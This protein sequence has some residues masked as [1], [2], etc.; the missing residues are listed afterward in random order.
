MTKDRFA[1][2]PFPDVRVSA[3][4]RL[5]LISL[6]DEYVEDYMKRYEEFVE[7]K[8][9]VDKRRWEHVKSKDNLRVYAE[10]TPKELKRRG[11]EPEN[12]LSATQRLKA[13]STAKDL[14]VMFSV[15]TFVGEL[16]DLMYGVL[17]PT[18]D[19][20]RIKAS[21]V[22]DLDS[23]AVLCSV[24]GPSKD[25]PFRSLVIKWMEID[26]PLQSTHLVKSRDFVYI[27]ATGTMYLSNGDRVGYHLLHSI[28]FPQTKPLPGKIRANMSLFGC[29]RQ[30]DRT[31]VD[32]FACATIDPGGDMLRSLLL[33]VA[34]G[35]MLSA[36][37]FVYCGQMKKLAWLL[38]RHHSAYD[39]DR[40]ARQRKGCVVC[41]KKTTSVLGSIGKSTCKIC[42]GCVCYSCKIRQC[43]S[44][45]VVGGRLIQRKVVVCAKCMGEST[46]W[47][48]QEAVRDQITEYEACKSDDVCTS[49]EACTVSCEL[50]FLESS[51]SILGH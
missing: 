36:T 38:Q 50:S 26:V 33:S 17:N 3:L 39:A 27:E 40:T 13:D 42:Y 51:A 44:F 37:N 43:I 46:Q 12:S 14:P 10:R 6:V 20:M 18:L 47:N 23:A 5:E 11:I 22:H 35:A 1:A 29:Y 49:Y 16:D 28:E 9:Q 8:R 7:G 48:A 15:G 25:D 41:S 34:A 21:Y 30:L 4:E 45:V 19:D 2:D 32:N 24:L 31:V